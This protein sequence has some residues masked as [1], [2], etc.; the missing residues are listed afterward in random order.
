V[1][2]PSTNIQAP[3]KLQYL[4]FQKTTRDQLLEL[5]PPEADWDLDIKAFAA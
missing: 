1:K 3:R 2:A 5:D 4:K